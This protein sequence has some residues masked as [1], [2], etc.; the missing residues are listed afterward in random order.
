MALYICFKAICKKDNN[1]NRT[2]TSIN[3]IIP[4]SIIDNEEI[5]KLKNN[6]LE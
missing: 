6:I 1:S 3:T 2:K 5:E 4:I